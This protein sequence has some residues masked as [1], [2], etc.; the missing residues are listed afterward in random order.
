M[1]VAVVVSDE[2]GSRCASALLAHPAVE[3]VGLVDAD[4]PR[5][6]GRR[7]VRSADASGFDVV[8]GEDAVG[9]ARAAGA[10][11]V[12]PG[13]APDDGPTVSH[14]SPEGLARSLAEGLDPPVTVALTVP[15]PPARQ[16]V[17]VGFPAPVGW[18]YATEKDGLLVASV[19][20]LAAVAAYDARRTRAVVDD[21]LFLAGAC[22]A[23]GALVSAVPGPAWTRPEAYVAAAEDLGIV[24]AESVIAGG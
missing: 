16:G 2:I 4:P 19:E 23:A 12:V 6:W 5:S 17:P 18:V 20:G 9:A 8:V 3:L 21:P 7:A 11:L 24:V 1:R 10:V 15:G 13:P 14:A 22:L